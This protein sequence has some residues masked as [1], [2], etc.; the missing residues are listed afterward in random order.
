M[1]YVKSLFFP[2]SLCSYLSNQFTWCK[3]LVIITLVFSEFHYLDY[4]IFQV[5]Y[6]EGVNDNFVLD[7][8]PNNPDKTWAMTTIRPDT[9]SSIGRVYIT[10]DPLE[11]SS[12]E[13][14]PDGVN[15]PLDVNAPLRSRRIILLT[16]IGVLIG[17]GVIVGVL[18]AENIIH[19]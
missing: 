16:V 3:I 18:S 10:I 11:I 2:G 5:I 14:I 4:N 12:I 8:A 6:C 7:I 9:P 1:F 15:N 19:F 17:T 13:T